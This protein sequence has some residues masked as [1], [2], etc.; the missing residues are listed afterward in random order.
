MSSILGKLQVCQL[1]ISYNK[2]Q[3]KSKGLVVK[4]EGAKKGAKGVL[5]NGLDTILI[6]ANTSVRLKKIR[7]C[8]MA[9]LRAAVHGSTE[10]HKRR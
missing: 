6:Y 5:H 4:F 10:F 3:L 2:I 8:S 1:I 7:K 9:R